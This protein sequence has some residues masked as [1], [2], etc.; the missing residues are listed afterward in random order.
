MFLNGVML[1]GLGGAAIPLV[2][3]LLWRLRYRTVDWGAM[4]FL[5]GAENAQRS[6]TRLKEMTL[7]AIRMLTV[8]LIAVALARPVTRGAWGGMA[9]QGPVTAVVVLDR[10][11]STLY[12]EAGRTRFE[13][14]RQATLQI[15]AGLGP[16][17]RAALVL[18]GDPEEVPFARPTADIQKVVRH[19]NDLAPPTGIADFAAALLKAADLLGSAPATGREVYLVCDRQASSWH[20]VDRALAQAWRDRTAA[21]PA[22]LVVIPVGSAQSENL[23][24]ESVHLVDEPVIRDVPTEIEV[25]VRNYGPQRHSGVGLK[26]ALL[27]ANG[28]ESRVLRRTVSVDGNSTTN[29]RLLTQFGHLHAGIVSV[30]LDAPG[31]EADNR[32]DLA[33]RVA[34]R[35]K[36]LIL[37]GDERDARAYRHESAFARLALSPLAKSGNPADVTV[38]RVEEWPV[39]GFRGFDVVVLANVPEVSAPQARALEQYVFEGGGLLIAP[40]NL[41]RIENYNALLWRSG[42]GVSP[43]RL[44]EPVD[45]EWGGARIARIENRHPIFSFHRGPSPSAL[46]G[47]YHPLTPRKTDAQPIA[48]LDTGDPL[49]VEGFTGAGRVLALAGP[50][51]REWSDLVLSGFYLPLMQSGVRWLAASR[52]SAARNVECGQPLVALVDK[53]ADKPLDETR[54]SVQLPGDR[55]MDR[56]ALSVGPLGP[57]WQIRYTDTRQ[58]GWYR[59]TGTGEDMV[60]V[61]QSPRTESDLAPLSDQRWSELERDLD[62]TVV[63]GSP[64]TLTTA[65]A[66]ARTGGELWLPCLV[67]AVALALM[68]MWAASHWTRAA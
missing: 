8:G 40:G 31:L 49:A 29:V 48:W 35:I 51:D 4:M 61:V 38:R 5:A 59:I 42:A 16:G 62:L 44:A 18:A 30:R 53:P 64:S 39:T 13:M 20:G 24:I 17:D 54:V 60:F 19:V 9:R 23:S 63:E 10:S 1:A 52:L 21:N 65:I 14:A 6:R 37:S 66:S 3:H 43:A 41:C 45:A 12:D 33:V 2:L 7:L 68:E 34:D 36:V 67:L 58:A 47:R 50:L 28:D 56:Q 46:I 55:P 15:L 57:S 22:R 32:F 11:Y 26:V 27:R 25:R